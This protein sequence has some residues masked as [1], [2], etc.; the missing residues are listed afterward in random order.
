[1]R[2]KVFSVI[3]VLMLALSLLITPAFANEVVLPEISGESEVVLDIGTEEQT[4]ESAGMPVPD[5]KCIWNH[6]TMIISPAGS[7]DP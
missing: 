3:V 4:G 1:M 6:S 5:W 2:R 7:S